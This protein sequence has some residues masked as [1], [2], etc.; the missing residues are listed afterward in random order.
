MDKHNCAAF[1]GTIDTYPYNYT[2]KII[3]Y[4]RNIGPIRSKSTSNLSYFTDN[5]NDIFLKMDIEGSEYRWLESLSESQL[6]KFKQ[7]VIELHGVNDDNWGISL[8]DKIKCFEKL[9]NTHYAVHIHGNNYAGI[10]ADIP[11]SVEISFSRYWEAGRSGKQY[12]TEL[13][14]PNNPKRIDPEIRFL[15]S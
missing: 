5:Y 15:N 11:L 1:D 9:L 4:K 12:P 13:D 8:D 14:M 2:K 7:I 6:K 10:N 3:F